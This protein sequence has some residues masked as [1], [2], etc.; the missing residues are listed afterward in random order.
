MQEEK[1]TYTQLNADLIREKGTLINQKETIVSQN[2]PVGHNEIIWEFRSYDIEREEF[3]VSLEIRGTKTFVIIPIGKAKAKEYYQNPDLLVAK[4]TISLDGSGEVAPNSFSLYGPEGEEFNAT[5]LSR[6]YRY[7]KLTIDSGFN[8]KEVQL[9]EID[10]MQGDSRIPVKVESFSNEYHNKKWS[11][12]KII[13]GKTDTSWANGDS[14][15]NKY[16][17][18]FILTTFDDTD[19]AFDRVRLYT[20]TQSGHAYRLSAFSIYGSNDKNEWFHLLTGKLDKNAKNQWET[21]YLEPKESSEKDITG[22]TMSLKSTLGR[23]GLSGTWEGRGCQSSES[24]WTIRI[25]IPSYD[26]NELVGGAIEYP[27][28]GCKARLEFVRWEN[29]T[30]VFRERYTKRG[31]CVDN[32]WLFL[33]PKDNDKLDYVWARPS[34]KK[35]AHT[36]MTLVK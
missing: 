29:S 18:W 30:A 23:N 8:R 17:H 27:S 2:F 4:A 34:G 7:I 19:C 16:P 32:G 13:D 14:Y 20:G 1:A 10:F 36:E 35:E 3:C 15:D 5:S 21:F 11:H 31:R 25:K 26:S 9:A 28:L 33:T 22:L 24:C 6:S 12:E